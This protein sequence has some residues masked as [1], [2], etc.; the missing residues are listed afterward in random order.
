MRVGSLWKLCARAYAHSLEVTN[1]VP[2]G[3]KSPAFKNQVGRPRACSKNNI[4]MINVFT[5]TNIYQY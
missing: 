4:N 1:V 5:L 3:T 2:A